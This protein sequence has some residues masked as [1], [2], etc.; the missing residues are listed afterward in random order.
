MAEV[1][2]RCVD[3]GLEEEKPDLDELWDRAMNAA[4]SVIDPEGATDVAERHDDYLDEAFGAF[5]DRR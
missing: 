5:L 2:R 4:G 3:K 1:I